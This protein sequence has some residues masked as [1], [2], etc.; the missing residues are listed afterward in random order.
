MNLVQSYRKPLN[1]GVPVGDSFATARHDRLQLNLLGVE[2]TNVSMPE[3]PSIRPEYRKVIADLSIESALAEYRPTVI[4]TPPLGIAIETS[5]IDIAC[6][7]S[8]LRQF[9]EVVDTEFGAQRDYRSRQSSPQGHQAVVIAFHAFGWEV[10]IFC[11]N[12]PIEKQWGVR[13][14]RV[15]QRLLRLAPHLRL[16]IHQ[17][18]QMGLKTEPAFARALRLKGDPYLAMLDLESNSDDQLTALA[19]EPDAFADNQWSAD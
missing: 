4:G 14:F 19:N 17:F 5:D 16:R 6:S 7:A 9:R 11:Q 12:L 2:F 18:K 13:H 1:L 3:P 10:E 8:D 15:E